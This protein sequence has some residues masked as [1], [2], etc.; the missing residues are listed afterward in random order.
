MLIP[1]PDSETLTKL[2]ETLA[3]LVKAARSGG[4]TDGQLCD[5]IKDLILGIQ[6]EKSPEE[7]V[8]AALIR[9]G[10]K[11]STAIDLLP[12]TD[13]GEIRA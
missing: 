6:G 2:A 12:S 10:V 4:M 3:P 9:A 5:V 8:Y 13:E 7:F 1:E 11:S